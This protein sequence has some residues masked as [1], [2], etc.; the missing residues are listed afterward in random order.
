M[1]YEAACCKTA[2]SARVASAALQTTPRGDQWHQLFA[3]NNVA[4]RPRR[5]GRFLQ[6][7]ACSP[8]LGTVK[9]DVSEGNIHQGAFFQT[10]KD[11]CVGGGTATK[12]DIVK[13][14]IPK[15]RCAGLVGRF[16]SW[17]IV[18]IH[19]D[20]FTHVLGS[21]IAV[22]DTVNDAATSSL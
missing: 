13:Q 21:D 11:A 3:R 20:H 9:I 8:T 17:M 19:P 2:C 7:V 15:D 16:Q 6:L 22:C 14:N 18:E 10:L 4:R 12:G 1:L 5:Q